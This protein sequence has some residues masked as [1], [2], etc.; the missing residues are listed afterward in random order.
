MLILIFLN[1]FHI[2]LLLIF[3]FLQQRETQSTMI[4]SVKNDFSA[5]SWLLEC[6]HVLSSA[7]NSSIGSGSSHLPSLSECFTLLV[8]ATAFHDS[9][10][11][12]KRKN[13]GVKE[14]ILLI[15][16]S[17]YFIFLSIYPSTYIPNFSRRNNL[18]FLFCFILFVPHF[19][20]PLRRYDQLT[21]KFK[22]TLFNSSILLLYA[23]SFPIILVP[24]LSFILLIHFL[25]HNIIFLHSS[26][27]ESV[28][29]LLLVDCCT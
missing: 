13:K 24:L 23:I 4:K 12:K 28:H 10:K 19:T 27:L 16:L 29:S 8:S 17:I 5:F 3:Y 18:H 21:S 7:K 25:L 20:S 9:V 26:P 6:A 11:G 14:N 1:S 15:N 22:F 2:H